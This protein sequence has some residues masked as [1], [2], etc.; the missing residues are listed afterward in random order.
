LKVGRRRFLKGGFFLSLLAGAG[1]AGLLGITAIWPRERSKPKELAANGP[2]KLPPPRLRG[3]MSVE[4]AILKRRSRREYLDK[5]LKLEDLAQLLWSAQGITDPSQWVAL[6]VP[7][8]QHHV[9]RD[10]F[11]L[12]DIIIR[13]NEKVQQE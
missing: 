11:S 5:P 1:V 7:R 3:E 6:L 10:E 4:E 8:I 13:E 9:R 2:I 12:Y